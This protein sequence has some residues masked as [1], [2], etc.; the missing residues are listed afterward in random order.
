MAELPYTIRK[1]IER[2]EPVSVEGIMLYP[3]TVDEI[4]E[5]SQCRP[6]LEFLQQSLPVA[7]MSVP[8]LDAFY[9]IDLKAVRETGN[10]TGLL[11]RAIVLLLLALRLGRGKS[12]D[13]RIGQA[14]PIEHPDR[15]GRLDKLLLV[16]DDE[17]QI[18]EITPRLFQRM[19]PI[20]AAQNGVELESDEANP[21][22]VQAERDI[23]ELNGAQLDVNLCDK[24]SWVA[25]RCG[26]EEREVYEWPILKFQRR[27]AILKRELDYLIFGI[28]Q[29]GGMVKYKNG[30]PCPSPCFARKETD[31]AAMIP[32]G[33]FAGGS[34]VQAVE[35][36]GHGSGKTR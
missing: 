11:S 12:M 8:L 6:A 18:Y 27:S 3:V 34:A 25:M 26:I 29:A 30:N 36:P 5:F 7:M 13:K 32:L 14:F 22:L 20:I 15:P 9:Q 16:S 1:K 21:E 28:G 4:E 31:S 17:Q 35:R 33:E 19:R 10:A 24:I 23:A 2:F